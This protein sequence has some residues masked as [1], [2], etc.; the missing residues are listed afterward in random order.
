MRI[1]MGVGGEVTGTPM[2]P[3]DIVDDIVR[4]EADGFGSAWSAHFSRGVD[5]LDILAVAG[6]RTSR[7][8]LGVGIVPTYPRHPLALA[9]QV[10]TTQAF[11]GGRLTLGV[12]VSHR[13]VIEDLHGLRYT[14]PAAHMRDYLSV[15]VPLLREG[16]V[17]YRGEFYQVDGGFAVPGTSPVPVLVGALSPLMV[18][19]AG[20]LADGVVTWLAGPRS[21]AEQIVPRLHAA[22]RGRPAPRVVAALPLAICADASLARRAADEVFARYAGLDNY[23]RLLVREGVSSPG[24]VAIVGTEADIEH[25][26]RRLSDV[27]VTELWPIVF[28]AGDDAAGSRRQTRALLAELAAATRPR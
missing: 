28:P 16:S 5:A 27:G 13:P 21:L 24:A 10:A 6:V 20:E 26:I 18:Q 8:E 7:I 15:L 11:S 1:A 2:S 12:G 19:A 4:A 17:R 22:A 9:Q 14:R 3:Q 23:R 25:Q